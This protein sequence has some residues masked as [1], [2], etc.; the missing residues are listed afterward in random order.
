MEEGRE[1]KIAMMD[2][3]NVDEQRGDDKVVN[4]PKTW[5]DFYCRWL[6]FPG[7]HKLDWY[8]VVMLELL[9]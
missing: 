9:V 6:V 3:N 8:L 4:D 5:T 1:I 7:L 2:R